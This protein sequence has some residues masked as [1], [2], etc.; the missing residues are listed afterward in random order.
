MAITIPLVSCN[1]KNNTIQNP[2]K[3]PNQAIMVTSIDTNNLRSTLS[4]LF[5]NFFTTTANYAKKLIDQNKKKL[6]TTILD[7]FDSIFINAPGKLKK[8]FELGVVF[9]VVYVNESK[10]TLT[11]EFTN[12]DIYNEHGELTSNASLS[13]SYTGFSQIKLDPE[14]VPIPEDPG[15]IHGNNPD[16]Y[17][18]P[19]PVPPRPLPNSN[20]RLHPVQP[21]PSQPIVPI[22]PNPDHTTIIPLV[23]DLADF[24][25]IDKIITTQLKTMVNYHDEL[26]IGNKIVKAFNE[27][28]FSKTKELKFT[29]ATV[30]EII[31]QTND[32][33]YYNVEVTTWYEGNRR[34]EITRAAVEAGYELIGKKTLRLKPLESG[35]KNDDMKTIEPNY[36]TI[37]YQPSTLVQLRN[38]DPRTIAALSRYDSRKYNIVPSVKDQGPDGLCWSYTDMAIS[39]INALRTGNVV[40]PQFTNKNLNY[41]PINFDYLVGKYKPNFDPLNNNP[42]DEHSIKEL[43]GGFWMEMANQGMQRWLGPTLQNTNSPYAYRKQLAN[44]KFYESKDFPSVEYIKLL[45]ATYG[46][47]GLSF[48][49]PPGMGSHEYVYSP[50]GPNNHAVT[51]V[52]WDDSIRPRR[53]WPS[54]PS[55]PGAF[56][57]KNSWGPDRH[58]KGYFYLSYDSYFRSVSAVQFAALNEY[59]NNYYYDSFLDWDYGGYGIKAANM[60]QAKVASKDTEEY[61]KAIN[62]ISNANDSQVTIKVYKNPIANFKDPNSLNNDPE[63]G[64]LVAIQKVIL[65]TKGSHTVDLIEPVRLYPGDT[66]SIVIESDKNQVLVST[67]EKSTNDMSFGYLAGKWQNIRQF[68]RVAR[69]KGFTSSNKINDPIVPPIVPPVNPLPEI[70]DLVYDKVDSLVVNELKD[71][72]QVPGFDNEIRNK[73]KPLVPTIASDLGFPIKNLNPN[74]LDIPPYVDIPGHPGRIPNNGESCVMVVVPENNLWEDIEV[75]VEYYFVGDNIV[76]PNVQQDLNKKVTI[77]DFPDDKLKIAQVTFKPFANK[78]T[79]DPTNT[80]VASSYS[81]YMQDANINARIINNKLVYDINANNTKLIR[82]KDFSLQYYPESNKLKVIGMGNYVGSVEIDLGINF[83]LPT[84]IELNKWSIQDSFDSIKLAAQYLASSKQK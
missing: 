18:P 48:R 83:L 64:E 47:A 27:S 60:Y 20:D 65:R 71:V 40:G 52:G 61:L 15:V 74:V 5:P 69:I 7:K 31:S 66:F 17:A 4:E 34:L 16:P 6:L 33:K 80:P 62:F 35:I 23:L 59:N 81:N 55:R 73:I 70:T 8:D 38:T 43:G 37:K 13:T 50:D 68:N 53:F 14:V 84:E 11:I 82:D 36:P 51:I 58:N 56:I 30:N 72:Q 45:V 28:Q 22:S 78:T 9:V 79:V 49:S 26:T 46:A 2:N 77:A 29:F 12:I 75:Y 44:L 24:D 41:D 25:E 54:R 3:N 42:N 10:D 19:R 76:L 21:D 1:S 67:G 57:I 39:E 63:S 32:F